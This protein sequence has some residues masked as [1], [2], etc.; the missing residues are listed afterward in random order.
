[1][2]KAKMKIKYIIL[3]AALGLTFSFNANAAPKSNNDIKID[4][5]AEYTK[6][7]NLET[8]KNYKAANA[9]YSKGCDANHSPSCLGIANALSLGNGVP[10]SDAQSLAKYLKSCNLGNAIGCYSVGVFYDEGR[11]V[12]PSPEQ[13]RNYWKKACDL[14]DGLGCFD[15]I[16]EED[17]AGNPKNPKSMMPYLQKS[18][19]Y[20]YA[21]A[22]TIMGIFYLNTAGIEPDEKK[23]SEYFES[24]CNLEDADSCDLVGLLYIGGKGVEKST[25][26]AINYFQR[27]CDLGAEASCNDLA[28]YKKD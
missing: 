9:L 12:K 15:Y 3:S 5:D 19:D 17:A 8:A 24:G 20:E 11:S 28:E 6:A 25:E 27:G 26:K 18:C 16:Y 1:M 23:A 21:R 13:G 14:G 2:G 22:C 4:W 7:F 10:K